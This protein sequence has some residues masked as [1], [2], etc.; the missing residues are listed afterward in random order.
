[1]AKNENPVGVEVRRAYDGPSIDHDELLGEAEARNR[2]DTARASSAGE[3]RQK[4]GE[5]LEATGMN[6]QAFS[7]CRTIL[8]KA[9]VEKSMDVIMSME[10]A[11]PMIKAHLVGQQGSLELDAVDP[12]QAGDAPVQD[13]APE[14]EPAAEVA[15][16]KKRG[17]RK[18]SYTPDPEIA[19]M[20]DDFEK[21]LAEASQ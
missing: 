5:F 4:I 20:N 14:D 13:D 17:G 21:H 9:T 11:L 2:E 19:E 16:T 15:P 3:S 8:K 12:V 18:P 7:W 6:S 10:R 1:M